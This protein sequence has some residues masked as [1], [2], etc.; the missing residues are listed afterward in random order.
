LLDCMFEIPGSDITGV[1]VTLGCINNGEEPQYSRTPR[2]AEAEA[3]P[4]APFSEENTPAPQPP[5]EVQY[6]N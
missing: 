2:E 5:A 1:H 4:T 3:E 6:V